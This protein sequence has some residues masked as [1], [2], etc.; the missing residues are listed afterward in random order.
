M[1]EDPLKRVRSPNAEVRLSSPQMSTS[2]M[3]VSEM[4]AA[5]I[6]SW[7]GYIQGPHGKLVLKEFLSHTLKNKVFV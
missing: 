5:E 3:L 7:Q 4:Y 1:E 6:Y 2:T